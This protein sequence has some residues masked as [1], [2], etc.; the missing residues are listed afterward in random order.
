[1]L[2]LDGW[3]KLSR[4][5]GELFYHT[6]AR[7]LLNGGLFQLNYEFSALEDFDGH[8]DDPAEHYYDYA[9]RRYAIDPG[10][11]A[12]AGEVAR[13]RVGPANRYLAYGTMLP[14]PS[15]EAPT[16]E[17]D[18]FRFSVPHAPQ[19]FYE[20]RGTI[21]LPTALAGAW[22]HGD[23]T[24]RLVANLLPE[25]QTVRVDGKELALPARRIVLVE[26]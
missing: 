8:S 7:V 26:H 23:D 17:Y 22:R 14:P 25:P 1:M 24:A 12:F 10:K 2:R 6:A 13:T 4:E 20:E 18:Y 15:V 9:P 21:T 3:A 11:A 16:R 19:V 5:A